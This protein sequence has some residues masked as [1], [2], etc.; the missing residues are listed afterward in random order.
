M[1]K[2]KGKRVDPK[3]FSRD[4]IKFYVI[5]I[6]IAVFMILPVVFM[7][8]EAFKPLGELYAFPPT[9]IVKEPTLNN[10]KKLFALSGTT[11][12]PMTRYLLNS[13][14]ITAVTVVLNIYITVAC[15]FV[16]SKKSQYRVTRWFFSL[17]QMA[18]MFV[19]VAVTVPRYIMIVRLGMIDTWAAHIFPLI[20]MP[21]GIFLM[22]QFIDDVPDALIEAA[23]VDGA[24]NFTVIRKIIIPMTRPAIATVA[25]LTF[26]AAWQATEA[27][28][29][30]INSDVMKTIYYYLN[31]L[32]T[33]NAVAAKGVVA[34]GTI[35][36]FLP[37]LI[38][39]ICMQSKVMSTMSHSGIK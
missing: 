15:A 39:F 10:F 34:A 29:N 35:L 14:F 12:V 24:G 38:M 3:S 27:S 6:P 32:Q 17:N 25:I 21:I 5:L 19:Q 11:G 30:F 23:Y 8:N 2:L 7:A 1:A 18:L 36:L 16:L 20:A 22:K 33:N 4:Q 26:Q 37:N 28:N 9:L 13:V 31:A